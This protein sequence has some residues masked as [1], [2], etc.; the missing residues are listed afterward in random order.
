MKTNR[1]VAQVGCDCHRLFSRITARDEDG[2]IIWRQRLEHGDR[3]ALRE[4]LSGWP[5]GTPVIL[6]GTFGWGWLSDEMLAAGLDPHLA[7]SA[8]MAAWRKARGLAKSDRIDAD[9][10]SELWT[11]Q[12]RWW[13][14]W[15]APPKVRDQREWLRYRMSLVQTHR[16]SRLAVGGQESDP[17]GVAPP[18][19][20]SRMFGSVW[21]SRAAVFELA[22]HR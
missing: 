1:K 2:R 11:Q 12:P 9:L 16:Q 20:Y 15:L 3:V 8:K 14:V 6:E 5:K 19:A 7:S 10:L 17:C 22:D 4:Q 21:N 13:E 18:W